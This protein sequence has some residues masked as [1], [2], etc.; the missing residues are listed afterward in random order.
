MWLP[1]ASATFWAQILAMAI[2][3]VFFLVNNPWNNYSTLWALYITLRFLFSFGNL[4][5]AFNLFT[6]QM[7]IDYT[8]RAR[9][10]C[11]LVE[12]GVAVAFVIDDAA[13]LSYKPESHSAFWVL[14]MVVGALAIPFSI[15]GFVPYFYPRSLRFP[16]PLAY[17]EL[18]E[19]Y[20]DEDLQEEY[21]DEPLALAYQ[22][23]ENSRHGAAASVPDQVAVLSIL[24]H[25]LC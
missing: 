15:L 16:S 19:P 13:E 10:I 6:E 14:Q 2:H 17:S 11:R 24:L 12:C 3:E 18:E 23:Q 1:H 8:R 7:G 5:L 4:M 9:L 20:T 25:D 22:A 21:S